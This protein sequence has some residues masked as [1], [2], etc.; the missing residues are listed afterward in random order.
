[1]EHQIKINRANKIYSNLPM[2][3]LEI[4]DSISPALIDRLTGSE[5][6]EVKRCLNKHWHKAFK[7]AEKQIVDEGC[8]WDDDR[9]Q[10]AELS[11]LTE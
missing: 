1:M 4:W 7:H 5:L 8:V 2:A 10:L 11:Y 3:E 9:Q 6:A